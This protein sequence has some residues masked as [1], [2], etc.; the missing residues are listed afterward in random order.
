MNYTKLKKEYENKQ[1]EIEADL[2]NLQYFS[3]MQELNIKVIL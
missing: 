3:S 2:K 1:A